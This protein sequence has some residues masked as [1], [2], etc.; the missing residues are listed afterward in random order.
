ML[1]SLHRLSQLP[2]QDAPQGPSLVVL[3]PTRELAKQVDAETKKMAAGTS[4]RTTLL[5]GGV[6]LD[7][8]I[9]DLERGVHAVIGTPGRVIDLIKR[10]HL[11]LSAVQIAVLDEADQMLDIGFLPDVE[12]LLKRAPSNARPCCSRLP[13][14][15]NQSPDRTL[16]TRPSARAH[17]SETGHRRNRRS[18]IHRCRP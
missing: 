6:P 16:P 14:R 3:C 18:K 2:E 1:P 8:Q 11:D 13:C 10:G 17:R 7:G 12:W 4:L 15:G 5:Y 9:R